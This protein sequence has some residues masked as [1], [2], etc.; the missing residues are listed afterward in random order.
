M[1]SNPKT[2][3]LIPFAVKSS[4]GHAQWSWPCYE[5]LVTNDVTSGISQ[6]FLFLFCL[7]DDR[8]ASPTSVCLFFVEDN[9]SL[10]LKQQLPELEGFRD[11]WLDVTTHSE[12]QTLFCTDSQSISLGVAESG[13]LKLDFRASKSQ[14]PIFFLRIPLNTI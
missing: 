11:S 6:S 10:P 3:I 9:S 14:N 2:W 8:I 12:T 13:T 7:L 5:R 4:F 1:S